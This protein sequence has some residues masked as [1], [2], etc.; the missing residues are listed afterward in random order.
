MI[1]PITDADILDGYNSDA[2]GYSGSPEGVFRPKDEKEIQDIVRWCNAHNHK[3]TPTALRSSTTGSCVCHQG[4][5]LSMEQLEKVPDIRLDKLTAV[6]QPGVNLGQL[7]QD[8]EDQ[9]LFF[10]PDPTS[11]N[12]CTVGGAVA[13]NASGARTL[14]YGAIRQWVR[15]IRVVLPTGEIMELSALEVDKN[16]TGYF[17]FQDPIHFFIGSEGT[18][19]VI[20]EIELRCRR[21]PEETLSFFAFFP[22]EDTALHAAT[23]IRNRRINVRC[24]EYFDTPCLDILRAQ[25]DVALPEEVGGMLFF[26]EE[27]QQGDPEDLLAQWI[28]RLEKLNALVDNTMVGDTRARKHE[29]KELRHTIPTFLNELGIEYKL[30]GGG[31]ISTDWAVRYNLI[32]Q[33]IPQA[34]EIC[35]RFGME[36][37]YC[38]G[39]IGNGHPH[40]NLLSRDGESIERAHATVHEMVRLICSQGGIITAEHGVGKV[41]KPFLSYQFSPQAIHWMKAFKKTLDPNLILA[42]G[43]IF[44]F[45]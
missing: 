40:F 11:E 19:G 13:C 36:E 43:N 41:K 9:G 31:K 5:L 32:T 21:F 28:Q 27:V 16:T 6:V 30:N 3:L 1:K 39:H 17:G 26:E 12:E 7:K 22:D 14:K 2:L 34:R 15:R 35:R 33:A 10:P 25:K 20:T 45:D 23:E 44:D 4:Y 29:M 38:Y 18:L 42:P 8:L 37:V 24:L